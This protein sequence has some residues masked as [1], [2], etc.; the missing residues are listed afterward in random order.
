VEISS[1]AANLKEQF[2]D[3]LLFLEVIGAL[4][5]LDQG[6][7][8]QDRKCARHRASQYVIEEGQLWHVGGSTRITARTWQECVTR[9]EAVDLARQEHEGGG[10]WHQDSIK[11]ALLDCIHCPG[12]DACLDCG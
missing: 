6:T 3:E 1:E 2:A 5:E 12:L 8:L 11:L 9:K 7:K 4:L 10:H